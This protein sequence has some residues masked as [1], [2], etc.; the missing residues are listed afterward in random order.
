M[1]MEAKE[2]KKKYKTLLYVG[3]D[4]AFVKES[5]VGVI[6]ARIYANTKMNSI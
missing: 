6:R 1:N 5:T 2:G 4:G 3:K